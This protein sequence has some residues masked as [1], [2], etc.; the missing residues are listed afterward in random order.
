MSTD[1]LPEAGWYPDPWVDG[2]IRWW[3]GSAW[4]QH[5]ADH[6]DRPASAGA[7]GAAGRA[8]SGGI[9]AAA[10]EA[11]VSGYASAAASA[12]ARLDQRGEHRVQV[13]LAAACLAMV[14]YLGLLDLLVRPSDS[15]WPIIIAVFGWLPAL[16]ALGLAWT[17]W[18]ESPPGPVHSLAR[19]VALVALPLV[20]VGTFTAV[21]VPIGMVTG[22]VPAMGVGFG[23]ATVLV[24]V[25]LMLVGWLL[26][27]RTRLSV[28]GEL[29]LQ[30]AAGAACAAWLGAATWLA[31]AA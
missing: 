3:S 9:D 8:G 13:A 11:E 31:L 26:G 24:G 10:V 2:K 30:L 18:V 4:T 28:P 1:P 23:V 14:A 15:S 16:L 20:V 7:V 21:I 25:G 27:R 22:Q 12:P 5:V 19:A 6:P 17:T 29:P